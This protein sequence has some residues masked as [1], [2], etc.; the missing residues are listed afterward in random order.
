MIAKETINKMKRQPTDWEK[1]FLNNATNKGLVSKN[2]QFMK[3][4]S[5]K[6][7]NPVKMGRRPKTNISPKKT[8]IWPI[9]TLKDTKHC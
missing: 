4:S 5:I 7:Y 3:F 1:I 2:K 8:Y 6:T 9:G